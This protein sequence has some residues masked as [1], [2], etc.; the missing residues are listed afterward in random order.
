MV[1]LDAYKEL[2]GITDKVM[3]TLVLANI[4]AAIKGWPEIIK[5]QPNCRGLSQQYIVRYL[6]GKGIAKNID[7]SEIRI[8]RDQ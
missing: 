7:S 4:I 2:T 5:G 1:G 3:S 8:Q 6:S